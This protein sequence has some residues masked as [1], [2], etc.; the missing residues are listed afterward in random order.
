MRRA[1]PAR[2]HA[3]YP[4]AMRVRS[5]LL[6]ACLLALCG[7]AAPAFADEAFEAVAQARQQCASNAPALRDQPQLRDAAARLARGSALKPALEAS[8]YRAQR[9]F[10]WRLT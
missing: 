10:E 2:Q 6:P 4:A 3:G 9:S 1:T 7:A 8:G 5:A